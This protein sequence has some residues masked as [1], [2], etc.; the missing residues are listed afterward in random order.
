MRPESLEEELGVEQ[1]DPLSVFRL[2]ALINIDI[3]SITLPTP[4]DFDV[5]GEY[6]SL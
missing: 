4:E 3:D 2:P 1:K 5:V 6:A